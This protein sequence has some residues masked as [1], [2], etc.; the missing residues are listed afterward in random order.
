MEYVYY[1]VM[2][3]K[4][5]RTRS[6]VVCHG[7]RKARNKCEAPENFSSR[8]RRCARLN[9]QCTY[10]GVGGRSSTS[11]SHDG[12]GG[13]GSEHGGGHVGGHCGGHGGRG[14]GVKRLGAD[15]LPHPEVA[16]AALP[17]P[18]LPVPLAELQVTGDHTHAPA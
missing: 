6:R 2:K 14:G 13:Q 1:R 5:V 4:A 12:G 7:C 18:H 9:L 17:R 8:C 15:P 16:P 11:L 10:F 3:K